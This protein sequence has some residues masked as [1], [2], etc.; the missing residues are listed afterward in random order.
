VMVPVVVVQLDSGCT[1]AE[2]FALLPKLGH[3][4]HYYSKECL[5]DG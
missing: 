3:P 2:L 4:V 1:K 5:F